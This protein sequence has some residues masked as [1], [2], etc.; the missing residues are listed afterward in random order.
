[1]ETMTEEADLPQNKR[2]TNTSVRKTL[3]QKMTDHNVPDTLQIYVTGHKSIGSLNNH[4]SLRDNHKMAI[5]N[6]LTKTESN[7]RTLFSHRLQA[8]EISILWITIC[9]PK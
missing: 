2:F 5:S 4:R 6:I 7:D 1:M 3:V 8:L 9:V